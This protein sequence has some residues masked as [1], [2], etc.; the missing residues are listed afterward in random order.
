[1]TQPALAP[2]IEN[3]LRLSS[4]SVA[5]MIRT[6][7][8]LSFSRLPAWTYEQFQPNSNIVKMAERLS[9]ARFEI[10]TN[11]TEISFQYRSLRDSAPAFNWIAGP[12]TVSLTT[13]DFEESISHSNG[14]LRIWNGEN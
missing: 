12:S 2:E 1:M 8:G 11:A 9:G 5:Q 4:K 14:D 3:K 10:E 13:Q 7:R 6:T